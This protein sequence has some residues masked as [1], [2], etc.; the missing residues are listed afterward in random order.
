METKHLIVRNND[1]AQPFSVFSYDA[2]P[3]HLNFVTTTSIPEAYEGATVVVAQP[4]YFVFGGVDDVMLG[5]LDD[6]LNSFTG[7]QAAIAYAETGEHAPCDWFQIGILGTNNKLFVLLE[8]T[9][10][11]SKLLSRTVLTWRVMV[12]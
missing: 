11:W 4:L 1:S 9:S 5:G 8:G 6:F 10:R 2:L 7:L 12:K 3:G